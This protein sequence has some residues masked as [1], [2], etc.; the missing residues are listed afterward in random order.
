MTTVAAPVTPPVPWTRSV[1]V[2]LRKSLDTRA[3]RWLMPVMSGLSLV[4][5]LV[6]Q[7]RARGYRPA[8]RGGH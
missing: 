5:A 6:L 4:V 8:T 7:F 2:E 1:H 3:G